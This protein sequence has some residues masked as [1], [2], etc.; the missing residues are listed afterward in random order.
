M[1]ICLCNEPSI[2]RRYE[3]LARDKVSVNAAGDNLGDSG[4]LHCG[5]LWRFVQ[6][7]YIVWYRR[8]I[9]ADGGER[10]TG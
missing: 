10:Q 7:G 2:R 6:G 5:V 8:P 1:W 4:R 9:A 3:I